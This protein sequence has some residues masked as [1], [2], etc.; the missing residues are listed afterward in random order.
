MQV[1]VTLTFALA[2]LFGGNAN[3]TVYVQTPT[4]SQKL[5]AAQRAAA[6]KVV[7]RLR[8]T[9]TDGRVAIVYR[10]WFAFERLSKVPR[11]PVLVVP[12]AMGH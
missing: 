11:P 2:V 12:T 7:F 10:R 3:S 5:A 1:N 6:G 4:R 9:F 8:M